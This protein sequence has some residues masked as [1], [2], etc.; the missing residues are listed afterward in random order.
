MKK[1]T[2]SGGRRAGRGRLV[3]GAQPAARFHREPD[4]GLRRA[5]GIALLGSAALV[6]G[7]L[8]GVVLKV[9]QVRLSYQL[10]GLRSARSEE[11]EG[12]RRLRVEVQTL[13]SLPLIEAKARREL[14]MVT[15]GAEQVLL[16]RDFVGGESA[17]TI[18]QAGRRMAAA[19]VL[20]VPV[21]R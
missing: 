9:Q 10:D 5:M 18:A 8:G 1:A 6:A 2:S 17:A 13:R 16:A 15:P 19:R 11:E 4:R 3:T 14:G 21:G 12:L 7:I 20:P